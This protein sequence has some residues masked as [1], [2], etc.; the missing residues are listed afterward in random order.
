MLSSTSTKL[1]LK[2]FLACSRRLIY[3]YLQLFILIATSLSLYFMRSCYALRSH[4]T[5]PKSKKPS[6]LPASPSTVCGVGPN[7]FEVLGLPAESGITPAA[8]RAHYRRVS[9][10]VFE[11]GLIPALT[12]G[13]NIPNASQVNV[14]RDQLTQHYDHHLSLHANDTRDLWNPFADPGSLA[15]RRPRGGLPRKSTPCNHFVSSHH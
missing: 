4:T 2:H 1:T 8:L 5:I 6:L 14:A 12:L 11:R 3:C 9:R 10:H 13:P 7:P 15:A